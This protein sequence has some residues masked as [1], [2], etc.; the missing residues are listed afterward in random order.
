MADK[1]QRKVNKVLREFNKGFAKDIA[2]YNQFRLKQFKR[3]GREPYEAMFLV[4]LYKADKLVSTKWLD[5]LEIVG[6]G[7]QVVGREMFWWVNNEVARS[8]NNLT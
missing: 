7:K 3:V 5:Y 2:P 8:A 1:T 4:N 6:V